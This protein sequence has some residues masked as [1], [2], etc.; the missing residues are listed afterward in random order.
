VVPIATAPPGGTVTRDAFEM[1]SRAILEGLADLGPFDGVLMARHGASVPDEHPDAD[2]ELIRRVRAAVGPRV[3]I[4]VVHDP[5]GDISSAQVGYATVTLAWQADRHVD[6]REQGLACANLVVR[7]FRGG[8][9]P[10]QAIEKPPLALDIQCQGTTTDMFDAGLATAID[11]DGG[12]PVMLTPR[13]VPAAGAG[14]YGP[15]GIDPADHR[16]VVSKAVHSTR[17]GYPMGQGFIPVDTPGLAAS[18]LSR[19]THHHRRVP[20]LPWEPGAMYHPQP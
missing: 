1:V 2:G 3:S 18:D 4:R 11:L 6:C 10:V 14:Q 9:R 17:D 8:I 15:L 7:T 19:S 13:A 16:V 20:M 12:G 5:H